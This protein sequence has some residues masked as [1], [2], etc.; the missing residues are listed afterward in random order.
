MVSP[1][2]RSFIDSQATLNMDVDTNYLC[3][4]S[5]EQRSDIEQYLKQV[6]YVAISS[7]NWRSSLLSPMIVMGSPMSPK[8]TGTMTDLGDGE[9][10]TS[11]INKPKLAKT[12]NLETVI[13]SGEKKEEIRAAIS[14]ISN[15]DLIF[16]KWGF[17]D[18]FEKGTAV[19]MLFWGI[20]G[21]GKTLAAKAIADELK[22]KL[23]VV[24]TAE[25]E[26][27]EPGGAERN[28]QAIFKAKSD[29]LI[30]FDECDSLLTD[31]NEVG[32]ILGAQINCLLQEIEKFTGVVIFTTNRLGKLDPA[33]ERRI[34]AKIE[35]MFPDKQAR[36]EIWKRM[37]PKKAPIDKDV[38]LDRLSDYPICGGNI[39]N[40]VLNAARTAAYDQSKTI[41]MSHF[42]AAI[43]KEEAALHAF[44]AEYDKVSHSGLGR[45]M[46]RG[47]RGIEVSKEMTKRKVNFVVNSKNGK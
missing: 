8:R 13:M 17:S 12:V 35:F 30:L 7:T 3:S 1:Q 38:D 9:E 42:V 4:V 32:P 23:K 46:V 25:I 29:H 40:S 15:S 47:S 6:G 28:I 21:T 18:I 43:E 44:V 19:T 20:P 36:L 37:M 2:L 10:E 41:K 39:K 34:T 27:S 11:A 16:D 5:G 26:S 22:M 24:G 31:R 45:Q 33:L 14:Q